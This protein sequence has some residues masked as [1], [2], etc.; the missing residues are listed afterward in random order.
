MTFFFVLSGGQEGQICPAIHCGIVEGTKLCNHNDCLCDVATNFRV[1]GLGQLTHQ[2]FDTSTASRASRSTFHKERSC[3]LRDSHRKSECYCFSRK[4]P[5][6]GTYRL[7]LVGSALRSTH[8]VTV[9]AVLRCCV[10]WKNER[11]DNA[12]FC[13]ASYTTLLR[14]VCM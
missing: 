7:R 4:S 6:S 3:L 9:E 5:V 8:G 11:Q 2:G 12:S 14:G 13:N 1:V 10:K